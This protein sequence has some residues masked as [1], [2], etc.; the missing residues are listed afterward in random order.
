MSFPA[1]LPADHFCPWRDEAERLSAELADLRMKVAALERRV[2][3]KSS[4]RRKVPSVERQ[5]RKERPAE[6]E[7]AKKK[8]ADNAAERDK[9]PTEIIEHRV[10]DEQRSCPAC[11]T[12]V[13]DVNYFCRS[14]TTTLAGNDLGGG[15][16]W[17]PHRSPRSDARVT[18]ASFLPFRL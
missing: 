5:L 2:F 18:V 17:R 1:H 11:G 8:R 14:T 16:Q 15:H 6:R 10:P 7:A 13:I 12:E 4:E 9:L 3:G